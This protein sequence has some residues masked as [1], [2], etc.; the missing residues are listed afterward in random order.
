MVSD[1]RFELAHLIIIVIEVNKKRR[2]TMASLMDL[3]RP[4]ELRMTGVNLAAE[5]KRFRGQWTNYE[6]ATDLETE[7]SAKRAALFLACVGAEARA[8]Y[9][10]M[11]VDEDA[12]TTNIETIMD[13]FE[14]L[15][16]GKDRKVNVTARESPPR[17]RGKPRE[18]HSATVFAPTSAEASRGQI[19][20]MLMVE[21]HEVGFRL[22]PSCS[23]NILPSS[24][25]H[26]ID[27][28]GM[29]VRDHHSTLCMFDNKQL[30]TA[31]VIS[32]LVQ[33]TKSLRKMELE[34]YVSTTCQQSVL[35]I[36]ACLEFELIVMN[37]KNICDSE[38]DELTLVASGD[39]RNLPS[40][41][42]IRQ[43]APSA[44]NEQKAFAFGVKQNSESFE[45]IRQMA[46][47]GTLEL[48]DCEN[49]SPNCVAGALMDAISSE[50]SRQMALSA[51]NETASKKCVVGLCELMAAETATMNSEIENKQRTPLTDRLET[52]SKRFEAIHEIRWRLKQRQIKRLRHNRLA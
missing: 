23:I 40:F 17:T 43:V 35:G 32:V 13:S 22:N 9:Q 24:I 28:K 16:G 1:W 29:R 21:G 18:E 48:F 52:N 8:A 47:E 4:S 25:L 15:C 30:P 34:F 11:A 44:A 31:G 5:W 38:N 33:N 51:V 50:E 27:P 2:K 49:V 46:T 41:E 36:S 37:H 7:A 14:R 10:A 39:K 19:H 42:E 45:A 12:F 20:S 6:V 3:P 26:R